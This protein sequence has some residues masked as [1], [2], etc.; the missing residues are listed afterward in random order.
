MKTTHLTVGVVS[1]SSDA[2]VSAVTVLA[3]H[4][5][6]AVIIDLTVSSMMMVRGKIM[7]PHSSIS[8]EDNY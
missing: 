2:R 1:A 6:V 8:D 5:R 3:S 7:T 4:P